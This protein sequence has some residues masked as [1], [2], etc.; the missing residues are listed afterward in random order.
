M[1]A[2][3]Y[4]QLKAQEATLKKELAK[5]LEEVN[6]ALDAGTPVVASDGTRYVRQE[7]ERRE[8]KV[9]GVG[10]ILALLRNH[11]E[12]DPAR[13]LSV[14]AAQVKGLPEELQEG[15][16]YSAKTVASVVAKR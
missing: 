9:T 16:V 2:D 12:L 10:G 7:S 14:T 11:K 8:Y 4:Q 15:L 3:R 13:Y 1:L 5:A 6:A